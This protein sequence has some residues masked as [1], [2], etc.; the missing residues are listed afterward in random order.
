M[1]EKLQWCFKV[2]CLWF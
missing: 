1:I 2:G